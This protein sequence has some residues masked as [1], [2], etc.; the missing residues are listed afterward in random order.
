M[1]N[2]HNIEIPKLDLAIITEQIFT[3][4]LSYFVNNK[5]ALDYCD[6]TTV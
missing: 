4:S 1:V 3:L 2:S 5:H 6:F